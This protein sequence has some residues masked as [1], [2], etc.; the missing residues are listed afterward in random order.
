[1]LCFGLLVYAQRE[2]KS[3]DTRARELE[4]WVALNGGMYVPAG[5]GQP[6]RSARIF[7]HPQRL[8]VLDGELRPVAEIPLAGLRHLAASGTGKQW[9]L[10]VVWEDEKRT[11]TA[12]FRFDGF[13]AEHMARVAETTI[14][15]QLQQELRILQA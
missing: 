3:V 4:V 7:V 12:S 14:R 13:F 5:N 15:S 2:R 11:A 8:I 9:E 1:M 6:T 10:Q